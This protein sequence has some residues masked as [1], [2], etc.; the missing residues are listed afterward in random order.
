MYLERARLSR[1]EAAMS[2]AVLVPL[3]IFP[4]AMRCTRGGFYVSFAVL[5]EAE[6]FEG[7]L[8]DAVED[9][10]FLGRARAVFLFSISEPM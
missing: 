2:L 3:S 9:L 4:L 8:V 5:W 7:H 1:T 6:I 10:L